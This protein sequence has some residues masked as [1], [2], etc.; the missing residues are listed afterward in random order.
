MRFFVLLFFIGALTACASEPAAV[1]TDGQPDP[2]DPLPTPAD[3]GVETR[4]IEWD[5]SASTIVFQADV[6][7]GA[8]DLLSERNRVPLCTI[9]GDNRVVWTNE[10]S[11]YHLQVLFDQLPDEPIRLFLE[12]L[13]VNERLYDFGGSEALSVTREVQPVVETLALNINSALH[14]TT[15]FDGWDAPYF[16]R[17]LDRCRTLSSAPVL[18]APAA[19]WVT[20]ARVPPDANAPVVLWDA[21]A[22]GVDLAA[23]ASTGRRQWVDAPIIGSLW[24]TVR[25]APPGLQFVQ[26]DGDYRVAL[27]VP[28]VSASRPPLPAELPPGATEEFPTITPFPTLEPTP[29]S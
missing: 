8:P 11:S 1:R 20:V 27:E 18:F 9:Y 14:I 28:N 19:A 6:V 29:N 5:R 26:G 22:T 24:Q 23:I 17:I 4:V 3:L 12:T 16:Q 2:N 13:V 21:A 10:V 25:Q 15:A 7:G